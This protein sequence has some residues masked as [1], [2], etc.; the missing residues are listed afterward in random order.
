MFHLE[1]KRWLL[2]CYCLYFTFTLQSGLITKVFEVHLNS[3]WKSSRGENLWINV[4][5]LSIK[6]DV[7]NIECMTAEHSVF[8]LHL[9]FQGV[10]NNKCW[11]KD[12]HNQTMKLYSRVIGIWWIKVKLS[13]WINKYLHPTDNSPQLVWLKET[14][15]SLW[16]S[17]A[18]C[19]QGFG[20]S[21]CCI[22]MIMRSRHTSQRGHF[23]SSHWDINGLSTHWEDMCF[24]LVFSGWLVIDKPYWVERSWKKGLNVLTRG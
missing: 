6:M 8:L 14:P 20:P 15:R 11:Y 13:K 9:W 16:P 19:P 7:C 3:S 21:D 2:Y 5:T 1:T 10:I 24:L 17:Q 23:L 4:C 22:L 18:C 12:C